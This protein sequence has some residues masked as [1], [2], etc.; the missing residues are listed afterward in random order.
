M[1]ARAAG[2]ALAAWRLN[3]YLPPDVAV[4]AAE[5]C[6]PDYEPRFDAVDKTY[7]YLFHLGSTRDPLLRRNAWH[8]GRGVGRRVP[9]QGPSSLV[10][11]DLDAMR[12]AC[13]RL[14]GTHDFRAFRAAADKRENTIRTLR[15]VTLHRRATPAS[16]RCSR[17]RCTATRS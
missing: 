3:R 15:R 7:R 10:P 16:L 17:S 8:L 9:A 4:R 6:A 11:L 12:A 14:T 13:T 1:R 5:A 2:R